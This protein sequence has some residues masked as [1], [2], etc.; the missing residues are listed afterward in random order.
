[1]LAGPYS[2]TCIRAWKSRVL[3]LLLTTVSTSLFTACGEST[4]NADL[5]SVQLAVAG[6]QVD[7]DE[8]WVSVV[9]VRAKIGTRTQLCSGTLIAP[10]L[11]I[12]AMHCVAPLGKGAFQCD[13]AGNA[14]SN[15]AGA[16]Q[17]G[18]AVDPELVEVRVGVDAVQNAVAARGKQVFTTGSS[19]ICTND[20]AVVLLDTELD[21]PITPLRLTQ[22]TTLGEALTIVG[23]GMSEEEHADT[24]RRYRENVRVADL[25]TDSGLDPSSAAPPRTLVVGPSACQGDSGG[26]AFALNKT[27]HGDPDQTVIVGVNSI[28]IGECGASDA[29]SVFTRVDPF[30]TLFEQAFEAAGRS[31]WQ[32]GQTYAGE[33]LPEPTP[34]PNP[35]PKPDT[36][37]SSKPRRLTRGC[38]TQPMPHDTTPAWVFGLGFLAYFTLGRRKTTPTSRR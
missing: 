18:H 26:P 34:E 14:K 24:M 35:K 30:D 16:G 7:I 32:E 10:D 3:R 28:V 2:S 31:L 17:L 15:V 29:R 5:G 21:L 8:N 6:G 13:Y 11:V 22:K 20:L 36:N 27:G 33:P 1:M 37:E 12:T 38:S 19:H 23:Y 9:Y 4:P 25:G